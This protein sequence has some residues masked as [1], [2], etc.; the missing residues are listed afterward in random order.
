VRDDRGAWRDVA[1]PGW[2][3]TTSRRGRQR[4]ATCVVRR[5]DRLAVVRAI[6]WRRSPRVDAYLRELAV[7]TEACLAAP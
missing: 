5:G 2:A 4:D 6:A 1:Q 3:C 7:A